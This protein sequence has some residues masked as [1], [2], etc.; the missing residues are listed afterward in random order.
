[1]S[2]IG[3]RFKD[4]SFNAKVT[5][6][7]DRLRQQTIKAARL[8]R[9]N[10]TTTRKLQNRQFIKNQKKFYANLEE[11]RVKNSEIRP[12]EG[13]MK[14]YWTNIWGE[15]TKYNKNATWLNFIEQHAESINEMEEGSISVEDIRIKLKTTANWKCP[16][17]DNI[18][19]YWLKSFT[20]IH[21]SLVKA[22][23][24]ALNEPIKIPKFLM[25]DVTCMLL[26]MVIARTQKTTDQSLVYLPPTSY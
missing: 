11:V 19:N 3:V 1:M 12:D 5:E 8:R 22:F 4:R 13:N 17:P 15:S 20:E 9:Y 26:K 18:H 25:T 6:E 7:R 10:K 2:A 21:K 23:S 24:E 16:G 14:E